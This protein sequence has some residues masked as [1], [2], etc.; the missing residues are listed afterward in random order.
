M[1]RLDERIINRIQKNFP[2]EKRPFKTLGEEFGID[3]KD[4][5]NR[6]EQLKEK[7]YIR[8]IGAVFDTRNLGFKSTLCAMKVPQER[9]EEVAA[10]VS[11]Y[12][13]VTH[14]YQREASYNLWFTL[15]A[16]NQERITNILQEI[17]LK[18]GIDELR[19]LPAKGFFKVNVDLEIQPE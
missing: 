17:S 2:I 7:G 18:T 9:L 10:L 6:L 3:E 1:D 19:D 15:V 12:R 8:R 13:E 11:T 16:E 5:I 4:M 14:N